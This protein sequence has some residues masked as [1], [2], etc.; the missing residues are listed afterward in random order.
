MENKNRFE[1]RYSRPTY[2]ERRYIDEIRRQ[3]TLYAA[4]PKMLRLQKLVRAARRAPITALAV[5]LILS[6]AVSVIGTLL[7]LEWD[8]TVWGIALAVTGAVILVLGL[9]VAGISEKRNK[10]KYGAEIVKL[11]DEITAEN[12]ENE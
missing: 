3:Y 10:E 2:S 4:S 11:C 6:I 1:Y 7:W 5:F 8:L 12:A 9:A